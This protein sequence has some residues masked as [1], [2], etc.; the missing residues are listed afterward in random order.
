MATTNKIE[1]GGEVYELGNRISRCKG[2]IIL[3]AKTT[4]PVEKLT[5]DLPKRKLNKHRARIYKLAKR[6]LQLKYNKNVTR[7]AKP[8][9]IVKLKDGRKVFIKEHTSLTKKALACVKTEPKV[10]SR[11]QIKDHKNVL[12]MVRKLK[13]ERMEK[14]RKE[15]LT[16]AGKAGKFQKVR[17]GSYRKLSD[18]VKRIYPQATKK[19]AVRITN[20]PESATAE[21]V[22]EAIGTDLSKYVT[23]VTLKVSKNKNDCKGN[24]LKEAFVETQGEGVSKAMVWYKKKGAKIC[25]RKV[26]LTAVAPLKAVAKLSEE[27]KKAKKEKLDKKKA[28]RHAIRKA[29]HERHMKNLQTAKK[30]RHGRHHP[31]FAADKIIRDKKT[32][33]VLT[34]KRNP[35]LRP[36]KIERGPGNKYKARRGIVRAT[37]K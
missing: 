25:D 16:K 6:H 14:L 20:L 23:N 36:R 32:G 17:F 1:V 30:R 2:G 9:K 19:N 33:R 18:I 8:V 37:R 24:K 26:R 34:I 7:K 35:L 12:M 10:R 29:N 5:F 28:R 31:K 11:A 27:E 22:K 3:P 21:A 15:Q 13:H 4:K